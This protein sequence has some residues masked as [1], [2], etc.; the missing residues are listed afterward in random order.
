MGM[1]GKQDESGLMILMA[2]E[3]NSNKPANIMSENSCDIR[4]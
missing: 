2:K 3:E 4:F 1:A